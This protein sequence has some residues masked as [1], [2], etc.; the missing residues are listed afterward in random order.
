[1]MVVGML[2]LGF[3]VGLNSE[4]LAPFSRAVCLSSP[5]AHTCISS[6]SIVGGSTGDLRVLPAM[7]NL[8]RS[9]SR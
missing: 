3:H 7:C 8:H 5:A 2:A 6:E 4:R 9:R 1:M